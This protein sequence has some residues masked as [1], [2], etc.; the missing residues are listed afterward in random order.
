MDLKESALN[1]AVG[2]FEKFIMTATPDDILD[3]IDTLIRGIDKTDMTGMEKFVYVVEEAKDLMAPVFRFV[4]LA[5]I[6]ILVDGMKAGVAARVSDM[7][8]VN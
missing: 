7:G 5:V 1:V 2:A 6:Q 4:L 3:T 8:A